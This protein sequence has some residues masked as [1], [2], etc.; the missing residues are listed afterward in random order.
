MT[1]KHLVDCETILDLVEVYVL[2]ATTPEESALVEA[3]LED[4]PDVAQALADYNDLIET[5]H[6]LPDYSAKTQQKEIP[7]LNLTARSQQSGNLIDADEQAS[8]LDDITEP[9]ISSRIVRPN[10]SVWRQAVAGL[11]IIVLITTNVYQLWRN[12][13]LMSEANTLEA[14]YAELLLSTTPEFD[15]PQLMLGDNTN[16]RSNSADLEAFGSVDVVF[17]WDSDTQNGSFYVT[18]LDASAPERLYQL[19]VLD[20]E[21]A[22]LLGQVIVEADD[23]GSLL[24]ESEIPI[25]SYDQFLLTIEPEDDSSQRA[26][27]IAGDI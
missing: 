9:E 6:Y 14:Q 18:G 24:F 26:P 17:A 2:G 3:H 15:T 5:M 21:D 16:L 23:I 12:N 10:F 7:P 25:D 22:V 8:R 4:C 13:Q 27:I 11:A 19:W 20:D 1:S